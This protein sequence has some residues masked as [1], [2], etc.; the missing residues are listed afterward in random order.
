MQ[1]N[2][3]RKIHEIVIPK[4]CTEVSKTQFIYPD[5]VKV[6]NL[7]PQSDKMCPVKPGSWEIKNYVTDNKVPKRLLLGINR[8]KI[9]VEVYKNDILVLLEAFYAV[10]SS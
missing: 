9:L 10:V 1:G 8:W 3:Y 7:P 6:S 5:L 2:E 4:F